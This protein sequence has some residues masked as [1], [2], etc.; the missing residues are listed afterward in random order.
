MI[1]RLALH[2]ILVFLA[3]T[4]APSTFAVMPSEVLKDPVLEERAREISKNV[5]CLVCQNQSI[6]DSNADLARD[7][8]KLVRQRLVAGDS[9]RQVLDYLV[10]RYGDFV[11]LKPP[12]KASTYLLWF[13]PLIIFVLGALSIAFFIRGRRRIAAPTLNETERRR[14]EELLGPGDDR[15][16]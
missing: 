10:R 14:I 9:D 4:L 11:L 8:R 12:V 15:P 16:G 5:R 3:L 2:T 13:G 7:L 1:S 6:D